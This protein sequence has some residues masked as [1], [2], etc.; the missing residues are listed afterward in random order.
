MI[1][2]RVNEAVLLMAVV[3]MEEYHCLAADMQYITLPMFQG[4]S[5]R[6]GNMRRTG[7]LK[8]QYCFGTYFFN[9]AFFLM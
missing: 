3:C 2:D 6:T 7:T 4:D 8:I 1:R 5:G 9:V